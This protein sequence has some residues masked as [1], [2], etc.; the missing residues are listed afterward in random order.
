LVRDVDDLAA[1]GV[2]HCD[3]SCEE[4]REY[5]EFVMVPPP[6]PNY[7]PARPVFEDGL[8]WYDRW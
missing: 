1:C 6:A 2:S 8:G 3:G 7:K 5:E 4:C